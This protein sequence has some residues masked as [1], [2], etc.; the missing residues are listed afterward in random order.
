MDGVVVGEET[1]PLEATVRNL[2]REIDK[3]GQE[4]RE[5]QR[6]WIGC[7]QVRQRVGTS[8]LWHCMSSYG[9]AIYHSM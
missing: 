7:Q 8:W 3:K 1:G 6:R 5:L 9:N 2:Q 4:S